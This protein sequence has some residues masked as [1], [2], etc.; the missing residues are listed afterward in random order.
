MRFAEG[1][2]GEAKKIDLVDHL[3]S[4]LYLSV[5]LNKGG[6]LLYSW[7]GFCCELCTAFPQSVTLWSAYGVTTPKAP[8]KSEI[9][10][11]LLY[12]LDILD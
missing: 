9:K 11:R 12:Y 8:W 7:T 6:R 10:G 4:V 1:Y 3:L 2:A 5:K